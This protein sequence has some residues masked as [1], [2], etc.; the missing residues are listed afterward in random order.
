MSHLILVDGNNLGFSG[1]AN[2]RL[3]AGDKNTHSTFTFIRKIRRI[4]LDNPDAYIMVLWDGRS[5]RNDVLKTYKANREVTDK[6]IADRKAYYL[7]KDDIHM[8]LRHLGVC[9]VK[10]D[11]WEADDLAAMYAKSWKG[12]KCTLM[13]GDKDWLQLVDE[14]TIWVDP[15][16]D[17]QCTNLN[18]TAFTGCKDRTQF[19]EQKCILGDAGDNIKGIHKVGEK[20][21]EK[22]YQIY[23]SFYDFLYDEDRDITWKEHF[24]TNLPSALDQPIFEMQQIMSKNE[25]LMYLGGTATPKPLNLVQSRPTLNEENFKEFCYRN[26]FMS[27]LKDLDLFLKPFRGNK[28]VKV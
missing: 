17:R 5:W 21:L 11:N 12:D 14:K 20:T 3:T 1:M 24:G 2:P 16:H 27:F 4:F 25:D 19:I 23:E 6:Q 28:F 8:A 26:A 18:F 7:Q 22:L 13:S 10:A 15:I 9:Q